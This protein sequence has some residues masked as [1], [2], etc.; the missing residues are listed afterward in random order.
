[1]AVK[2]A[3]E[4]KKYGS[5]APITYLALK[6]RLENIAVFLRRPRWPIK[7][8]LTETLTELWAVFPVLCQSFDGSTQPVLLES[9]SRD[10]A[11][12]AQKTADLE[13]GEHKGASK[14]S[15]K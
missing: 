4:R 11:I 12:P 9:C 7:F 15:L 3:T 5:A 6:L 2:R 8:A 10:R 13:S 1:M 14:P